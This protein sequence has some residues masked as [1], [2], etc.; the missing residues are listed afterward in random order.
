MFAWAETIKLSHSIFA[1]PFAIIAV[2]LAG[3]NLVDRHWPHWGQIVLVICCMV[4]A[5][6]VAM[7][8]NRIADAR[9]DARNPRTAG[10]SLPAGR[11]TLSAAWIMLLL[12]ALTFMA[13]CFGFLNWY[14]N[15]WPC[16]LGGPVL[17]LLCAYSLTKRFTKFSH[18][19]LGAAI[20]LS[21]GAAWLAIDPP[22]VGWA[23]I[24]LMFA[25]TCWIA[26]F[27]IIYACQD[28][29][30]DR[31]EG[32]HSLPASLGP[33]RAL[34]V[35]RVLHALA[36]IALLALAPVAK[37]G[38]IYLWGVALAATLLVVE[39]SL[40]RPGDYRHVNVAFFTVNGIVSLVLAAAAIIDI[41]I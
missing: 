17:L 36:A 39:N 9:I 32:L 25:V 1:L 41:A 38:D 4:A 3:R 7:T 33:A 10:R 15:G 31:R 35:A 11:L 26:G 22:S 8:F 6:S 27:D 21:P 30:V 18:L 12:S 5:R 29:D 28:I 2:V 13:G 19:C 23:T 24:I 20:G 40:V 16:L 14:G 37:L 34:L